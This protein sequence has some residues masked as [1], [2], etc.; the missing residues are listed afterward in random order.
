MASLHHCV[1]CRHR[2]R[3]QNHEERWE[4]EVQED[5]NRRADELHG[6]HS[7]SESHALLLSLVTFHPLIIHKPR[8][9]ILKEL[10]RDRTCNLMVA[11]HF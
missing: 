8:T 7:K 5:Q 2:S 9:L 3:H 10:G 6:L 4:D 1:I 11:R